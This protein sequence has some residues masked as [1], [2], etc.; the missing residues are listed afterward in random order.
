MSGIDGAGAILVVVVVDG[1]G[2]LLVVVLLA[3]VWFVVDFVSGAEGNAAC[4]KKKKGDAVITLLRSLVTYQ[5]VHCA[6]RC[7]ENTNEETTA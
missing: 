7:R 5:Y 3:V 6:R 4:N 2:L 1:R